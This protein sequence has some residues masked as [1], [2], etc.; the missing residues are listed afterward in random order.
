MQEFR[1][2]LSTISLVVH[3]AASSWVIFDPIDFVVKLHCETAQV[4]LVQF[5]SDTE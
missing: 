5:P 3:N 4:V 2:I 1:N